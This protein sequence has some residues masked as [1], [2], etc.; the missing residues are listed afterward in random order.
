MKG[1]ILDWYVFFVCSVLFWI[2]YPLMKYVIDY[3]FFDNLN[4][5]LNVITY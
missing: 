1:D 2:I 4:D 3:N 5:Y